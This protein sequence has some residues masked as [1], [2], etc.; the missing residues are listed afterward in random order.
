[1]KLKLEIKSVIILILFMVFNL[2]AQVVIELPDSIGIY[3][4]D[5]EYLLTKGW[6]DS[7][8]SESKSGKFHYYFDGTDAKSTHIRS[9]LRIPQILTLHQAF[10]QIILYYSLLS[11]ETDRLKEEVLIYPYFSDLQEQPFLS[12]TYRPGGKFY[13]RINRWNV[14]PLPPPPRPEEKYIFDQ[15]ME[16]IL[17]NLPNMG[18][19][20][21]EIFKVIA[22]KNKLP[23]GDVQQIYQNIILWQ[24]AQ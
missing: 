15:I 3:I 23:V 7:L 9:I 5:R 17:N 6:M 24:E 22:D 10:R 18:D 13:F 21:A 16:A 20:S 12:C 14:I 19:P 11:S 8:I 4:N 1:M 2:P